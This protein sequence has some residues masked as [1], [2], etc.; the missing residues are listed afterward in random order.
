MT[1]PRDTIG[2]DWGLPWG[3]CDAGEMG[4]GVVTYWLQVAHY[5]GNTCIFY[6]LFHGLVYCVT[7]GKAMQVWY[8]KVGQI[9]KN[10]FTGEMREPIDKTRYICQIYNR[11]GCE[12]YSRYKIEEWDLYSS[13]SSSATG[14]SIGIWWTLP[15]LR[16]P[17]NSWKPGIRNL[18]GCSWA[19]TRVRQK[20]SWPSS[21]L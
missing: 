10:C 20:E 4:I 16:K 19:C 15:R 17:G 18:T 9:R 3:P 7:W 5:D 8:E 12:T 21:G 1:I 14:W 11:M 6:N 13:S 2:S